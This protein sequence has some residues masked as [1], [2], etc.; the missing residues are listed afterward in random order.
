MR[1]D[2]GAALAA[3]R[4]ALAD[5]AIAAAPLAP[6]LLRF[7]KIAPGPAAAPAGPPEGGARRATDVAAAHA[8]LRRR[9]SAD[10]PDPALAIV[11]HWLAALKGAPTKADLVRLLRGKQGR[12]PEVLAGR[13]LFTYTALW[14]QRWSLPSTPGQ[15]GTQHITTDTS[16]GA[17]TY[18]LRLRVLAAARQW[19]SATEQVPLAGECAATPKTLR[20]LR[21]ALA[22]PS[23][24]ACLPFPDDLE[25]GG[26]YGPIVSRLLF[27]AELGAIGD[28][29]FRTFSA[30]ATHALRPTAACRTTCCRRGGA[31]LPCRRAWKRQTTWPLCW[32]SS[33]ATPSSRA[34]SWI[35]HSRPRSGRRRLS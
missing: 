31:R 30:P 17:A 4:A 10:A 14:A 7:L 23:A 15:A 29:E 19:L 11:L 6:T 21:C 1:I 5:K 28:G 18:H 26:V 8:L 32:R 20:Q 25:N 22:D 9:A 3:A 12:N 16:T 35:S 34:P 13:K 33:P 27:F 2:A 24:L